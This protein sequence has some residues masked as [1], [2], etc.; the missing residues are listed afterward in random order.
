MNENMKKGARNKLKL[1]NG[2]K[3]CATGDRRHTSTA[4]TRIQMIV[5]SHREGGR[6]K[7]IGNTYA[8]GGWFDSIVRRDRSIDLSFAL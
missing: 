8:F 7:F 3:V 4:H 6:E 5:M 1:M 2:K